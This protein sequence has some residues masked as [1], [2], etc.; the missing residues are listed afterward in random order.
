MIQALLKEVEGLGCAVSQEMDKLKLH[1][2]R[3]LTDNIKQRL[4]K[5]KT[6]I[7][8]LFEQQEKARSKGWLVY[9]NGAAYEKQVSRNSFVYLFLENDGTYTAWRGTWREKDCPDREKVIIRKVDFE[10]AFQRA[11]KYVEWFAK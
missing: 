9:P 8:K 7:L 3:L 1:D 11:N 4:K 6:E 10:T 5:Y 2:P